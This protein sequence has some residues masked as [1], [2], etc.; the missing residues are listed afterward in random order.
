MRFGFLDTLKIYNI[1]NYFNFFKIPF[2]F[3][4]RGSINVIVQ[5]HFMFMH[6]KSKLCGK[7]HGLHKYGIKWPSLE[8]FIKDNTSFVALRCLF[9]QKKKFNKYMY[10]VYLLFQSPRHWLADIW[11]ALLWAAFDSSKFNWQSLKLQTLRQRNLSSYVFCSRKINGTDGVTSFKW[12]NLRACFRKQNVIILRERALT[13]R[14]PFLLHST[15]I[16]RR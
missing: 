16:R 7:L 8:S 2:V 12:Q 3:I 4:G 15:N 9:L 14:Q 13:A 10:Y 11:K 5:K 6:S 1:F